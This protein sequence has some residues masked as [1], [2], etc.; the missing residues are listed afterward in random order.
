MSTKA[1]A[2]I[3][4]HEMLL[5]YTGTGTQ[6]RLRFPR[7]NAHAITNT[8]S[9]LPQIPNLTW[10][11]ITLPHSYL[12]VRAGQDGE[13]I[14]NLFLKDYSQY[15]PHSF[16]VDTLAIPRDVFARSLSSGKMCFCTIS[17]Q[18]TLLT[19]FILVL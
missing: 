6:H 11:T 12:Q 7:V 19:L 9:L 14:G 13:L 3:T 1:T 18:I 15:S 2:C 17:R 10:N 8:I 4:A 5:F 16:Y